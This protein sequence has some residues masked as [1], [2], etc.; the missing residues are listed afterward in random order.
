V[1]E[2]YIRDCAKALIFYK[3]TFGGEIKNLQMSDNM[4]MFKRMKGK[5]VHAELHVN[6]RCIF[7]FVD[8]LD[9]KRANV[10]NVTLVLHMQTKQRMQQVYDALREGGVVGMELQKTYWGEYHAI[11]TD[12]F[13][14]PWALNFTPKKKAPD[15]PDQ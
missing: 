4:E 9:K 15:S 3:D 2:I 11:V 7:Y 8:V 1:P 14:A 12:R 6:N 5:V 10:G 13:G